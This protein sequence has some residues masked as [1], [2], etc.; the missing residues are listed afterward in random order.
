[1]V[2][3]EMPTMKPCLRCRVTKPLV[4]FDRDARCRGGRRSDC[5]TCTSEANPK[6][7]P[8]T[9]STAKKHQKTTVRRPSQVRAEK[10]Y[11]ERQP[12]SQTPKAALMRTYWAGKHAE[13]DRMKQALEAV[14]VERRREARKEEKDKLE[15]ERAM[16]DA[17]RQRITAG[18][19]RFRSTPRQE[20]TLALARKIVS[21]GYHV[22]ADKAHPDKGGSTDQLSE[23]T[24]ARNWVLALTSHPLI[25]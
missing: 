4:E 19:A 2:V 21:T 18:M 23:L 10:A 14:E 15:H 17:E 20:Q 16:R 9:N 13:M 6:Q 22:L 3:V 1:M 12:K 25:T 11:R 8:E 7:W 5:R 24:A